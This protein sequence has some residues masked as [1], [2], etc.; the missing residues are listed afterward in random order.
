M[1]KSKITNNSKFINLVNSL[2]LIEKRDLEKFLLLSSFGIT[3][4]DRDLFKQLQKKIEIHKNIDEEKFWKSVLSESEYS[5]KNRIK[6]RLFKAIEN[7]ICL[8]EIRK[9]DGIRMYLLTTFYFRNNLI[10]N[11]KNALNKGIRKLSSLKDTKP[12]YRII[13]YWFHEN[14]VFI[15]KDI[16][17]ESIHINGM[18]EE[19]SEFYAINKLRIICE[20][21]NRSE[22]LNSG[23]DVSSYHEE[24]DHLRLS[25]NSIYANIYF[26]LYQLLSEDQYSSFN[27]V[28]N[29]IRKLDKT[30]NLGQIKEVYVHLMNYCIRKINERKLEYAEQ[31]INYSKFLDSNNILLDQKMMSIG[32]LKNI[33]VGCYIIDNIEWASYIMD[34]YS[35]CWQETKD[36]NRRDFL[37]LNK[38]FLALW[39]NDFEKSM[40]FIHQFQSSSMYHKD[41]YYKMACDKLLLKI[42]FEKGEYESLDNKIF[43]L[44]GYIRNREKLSQKRKTPNLR[45]LYLLDKIN[46]GKIVDIEGEKENIPIADYI[47][48]KKVYHRNNKITSS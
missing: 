26:H 35:D 31:F 28:N 10:S 9:N 45:F 11:L 38:A 46:R 17:Q 41:V 34:K 2:N 36:I 14:M 37:S 30:S 3:N 39:R 5:N 25:S 23:K 18:E 20:K 43:V 6:S 19:L 48:L 7:Y 13:L 21:I 16:R 12:D 24:V 4:R 27:I 15:T 29:E 40:D 44:I 32:R 42:F 1:P 22:I 8:L 33:L 47:W